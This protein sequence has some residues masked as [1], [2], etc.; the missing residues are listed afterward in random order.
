MST[1]VLPPLPAGVSE[2]IARQRPG[3]T[4][5]RAFYNDANIFEHDMR[6]IIE[7]VWLFV[8]HVSQ[9]PKPGDYFLYKIGNEE[10]IIVRGKSGAVHAHFNVCRHRGSRVCLESSGHAKAFVCPYHAWTYAADGTL[11]AAKSMGE[12]FDPS[13]H[14]LKRCAVRVWEG[15]IHICLTEPAPGVE[16]DW[17]DALP[18]FAPHAMARAKIA[19][20]FSWT[21]AANWKLVVENFGECYHCSHTHPEYCHVMAHALP[22]T[23]SNPR[24]REAFAAE[25]AAWVEAVKPMGY[26][27]GVLMRKGFNVGRIPV[28]KGFLTQTMDGKPA[29]PL[30]GDFKE[31]DGGYTYCRIYP[32]VYYYA[33]NDFI[34]IPRFTPLGPQ[35]T[36]VT[37]LW[38]V[39][40]DAVE[41]RDYDVDHLT[42]V[43]RVT[44]EQDKTIVE[45]NQAG[46]NSIAYEPGPY[47]LSE[48]GLAKFNAWY[49]AKLSEA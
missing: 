1:V 13:R 41:G 42:H 7:R 48:L 22:D 43:Y 30:M 6:R 10:I 34:T 12:D 37:F 15:M 5:D 38:L 24:H 20:N 21:V 28:G 25:T 18:F 9:I 19:A 40:E 26:P 31:F 14:G 39:R 35:K 36:E 47:S 27:T 29:A 32:M 11:L 8:G 23:T 2:L 16:Q 4:L 49:L 33:T 3:Y 17:R 46:V 44:T 45:D